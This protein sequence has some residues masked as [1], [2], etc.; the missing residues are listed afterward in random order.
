MS[1]KRFGRLVIQ[2]FLHSRNPSRS[3]IWSALC[4]CGG[5]VEV[6]GKDLRQGKIKSCGCICGEPHGMRGTKFYICWQNMKKRCLNKGIGAYARYG[7]KGITVCEKWKDFRIFK[8]D[9]YKSYLAHIQ[10]FGERETTLDRIDP[11]GNYE[12]ENIRWA[13]YLEQGRNRDTSSFTKL[14]EFDGETKKI[15]EWADSLR[16]KPITL[17]WRLKNWTIEE[18]LRTPVRVRAM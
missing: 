15:S 7:G 11:E 4:D 6:N 5:T 14:I 1:G 10:K 8:K 17:Y 2:K 9:L 18:A 13:T 12:P 16:M 3:A